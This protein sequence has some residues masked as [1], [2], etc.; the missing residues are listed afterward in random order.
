VISLEKWRGEIRFD[1]LQRLLSSRNEAIQFFT[2]RDLLG[3][4]VPSIETLWSLPFAIR[5]VHAQQQDGS[6]KYSGGKPDVRSR[7]NHNQI[8]TYRKVGELVE[9]YGFNNR[10]PAIQKAASFLLGFQTEEGDLRGIYGNQYTPNYTAGIIEVL[11]K[12]GYQE[13]PRIEKAL[14][15]LLSIRQNDGGCAIPIRTKGSK[16]DVTAMRGET[17]QPDRSKPFSHLVTVVVLRAFAAHEIYRKSIEAKKAGQ[18]LASRVFKKDP[19]PDRNAVSFWTKFTFPFW[20]TDLLSAF[21]SLTLL[22]FALEEPQVKKGFQ[23]LH[24]KLQ[25]T[26]LWQLS[27]LNGKNDSETNSWICLAIC[28]VIKRLFEHPK[29]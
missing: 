1:P 15:W 21:D 24:S 2:R 14:R 28:R 29:E 23:W 12:A 22:G 9:K 3:D 13:D 10:H 20:F 8:E 11:I 25:R 16:L 17:T 19:C 5:L 26:G 4:K 6:W 7:P 18:L 27:I